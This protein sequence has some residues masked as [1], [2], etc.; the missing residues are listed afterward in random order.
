[1]HPP[2]QRLKPRDLT[3]ET[4]L[5]LVVQLHLVR[6]ERPPQIPQQAQ[7]VRGVGVPLG[8]VD[9]Y[10]RTVPLRL[11]HR[12]VRAAQQSLGVEGV[13]GEDGD[14][15][16]GLQDE[17]EPV[18]VERGAE[19]GDKVAGDPGRGRGGVGDGQQ[20][21]ELVTAE[22]RGLRPARQRHPQPVR[23]LQQQPV[24]G[25]MAQGVV[26]RPEPVEVDEH[27]GGLGADALGVVQ[28]GPDALQEPLPVGQPGQRVA[29]LL[30]GPGP[31][32]P[33]GGVE[34]DERDREERQ[35]D[36]LRH[37]DHADQ[38]GDAEQGHGDQSLSEQGGAGDG[39][40]SAVA[41]GVQVPEQ[42]AGHGEVRD[43]DQ[44]DFG[45]GVDRPT[46]R[47]PGL[48]DRRH[49]A[50][51]AQ[52]ECTGGDAEDVHRA[53]QHALAPAVAAGYAD[54]DDHGEAD[55]PGGDP[56][57]EQQDAEGE[58]GARA[59]AAPPAG[60]AE[61]DQVA[62]DDAGQDGQRPADRAGREERVVAG[63]RPEEAGA[64][65]ERGRGHHPCRQGGP[66]Q[67]ASGLAAGQSGGRVGGQR[68]GVAR[69]RRGVLSGGARLG[70]RT[71]HGSRSPT[72]LPP[73]AG[74]PAQE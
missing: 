53:V 41:R 30:L 74:D 3:V 10:A 26:D 36:R 14:A 29:Q 56:A 59:G 42:G 11:V 38:R 34:G 16:A 37:G 13:V 27:E 58:G 70:A 33:Q 15:R 22:P 19:R 46:V 23:D 12:D 69:V 31:G 48:L 6:V 47:V 72:T 44:D 57:V 24:T 71:L 64:E 25:E 4:D 39:G 28:G 51:G 45:G 65:D 55:H 63:E 60:A 9:L 67:M 61:G 50:E 7:P 1:M 40:Q 66:A 8:L 18:E 17:G 35:Q 2:H 49:P 54:Q 52:H 68:Y 5:G 21:G 20:H 32:H 62:D 73:G 43:G